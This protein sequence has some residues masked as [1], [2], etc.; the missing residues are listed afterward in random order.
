M[1]WCCPARA[2]D[3]EILSAIRAGPDHL[4]ILDASLLAAAQSPFPGY[5]GI[6]DRPAWLAVSSLDAVADEFR[7]ATLALARHE[8]ALCRNRFLILGS[9]LDGIARTPPLPLQRAR[10]AEPGRLP[11]SDRDDLRRAGLAYPDSSDMLSVRTLESG[12]KLPLVLFRPFIRIR[13]L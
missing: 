11:G 4:D 1:P 5:L 12:H 10:W 6:H 2:Q 3:G 7:P 13:Y 8:G 9:F